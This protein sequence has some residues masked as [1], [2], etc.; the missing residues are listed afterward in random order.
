M[1]FK[2]L[3]FVTNTTFLRMLIKLCVM[4]TIAAY[5]F[6]RVGKNEVIIQ[7]QSELIVLLENKIFL[8]E[9][10]IQKHNDQ[11]RKREYMKVAF[12]ALE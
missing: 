1:N 3:A 5:L 6:E 9:N 12:A 4:K 10:R 7:K 11:Q 2:R 8:L